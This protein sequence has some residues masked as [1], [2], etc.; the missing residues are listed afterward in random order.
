MRFVEIRTA[1]KL[2]KISRASVRPDGMEAA[3]TQF[4]TQARKHEEDD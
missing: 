3:D 2:S 4:V 1:K